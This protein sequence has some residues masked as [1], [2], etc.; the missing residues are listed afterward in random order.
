MNKEKSSVTNT[1]F[2]GWR[3]IFWPVYP[4]EAPK[5][6]SLASM[7][8]CVLFN[9]TVLK[10]A[11]DAIV[12]T[13]PG[14]GAEALNFLKIYGALPFMMGVMA[15]YAKLSTVFKKPTVFYTS[16]GMFIGFFFIF[17][18]FLFPA[19]ES[20]NAL[21]DT[22]TRWQQAFPRFQWIIPLI[23]NWV[24]S[25]FYIFADIWG[26]FGLSVL[27][28]QFANE[29][30]KVDES[31]RFYP[32]FG[33]IGNLGPFLAGLMVYTLVSTQSHLGAA[34]C[35]ASCMNWIIGMILIN[36]LAIILLYKWVYRNYAPKVPATKNRKSKKSSLWESLKIVFTSKYLLL[37]AALI[38][39]YGISQNM[40]EM[41]WKSQLKA[42]YPDPSNYTKTMGVVSLA[43]SLSTVLFMIIGSNILRRFGWYF[44]ALITPSIMLVMGGIFFSCVIASEDSM[45]PILNFFNTNTVGLAVVLGGVNFALVNGIKYSL[46]DTTKEMAYIPLPDQ[47]KTQGKA[48]ADGVGG[49]LGKSL[50]GMIQQVFLI[51]IVGATQ[52]DLAPYVATILVIVCILW[53]FSVTKLRQKFYELEE[54]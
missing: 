19:A 8:F 52:M 32:M 31:K 9:Y 44:S 1:P 49:R 27:F 29:L 10:D 33:L 22:I 50:G 23:G 14:S 15:L 54:K 3:K 48:A 25:L 37:I 16:M 45:R 13:A 12:V 18:F 36:F 34:R 39:C 26:G 28:W 41:T 43:T 30:T 5:V 42:Q 17:G 2:Q 40:F 46:F 20:L 47:L 4:H 35:W 38:L 6:L 11:K 21:P 53:F 51:T 24:Y 7:M